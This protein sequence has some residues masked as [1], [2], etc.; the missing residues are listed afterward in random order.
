MLI[1]SWFA[2]KDA[3]LMETDEKVAVAEKAPMLAAVAMNCVPE[4][5]AQGRELMQLTTNVG[6]DAIVACDISQAEPP[7]FVAPLWS[8][9]VLI[10][11]VIT[12]QDEPPMADMTSCPVVGSLLRSAHATSLTLHTLMTLLPRAAELYARKGHA[13]KAPLTISPGP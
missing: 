10:V 13:A 11:H 6:R 12:E 4:K 5:A 1:I 2:V 3:V 7:Q 9:H 8:Y